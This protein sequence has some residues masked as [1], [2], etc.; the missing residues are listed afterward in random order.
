M[1]TKVKANVLANT[2]NVMDSVESAKENKDF[3]AANA[4]KS[5]TEILKDFITGETEKDSFK[6]SESIVKNELRKIQAEK[7]GKLFAPVC[8][9]SI[10]NY[11]GDAAEEVLNAEISA[12][13]NDTKN[14][15]V[16]LT[17]DAPEIFGDSAVVTYSLENKTYFGYQFAPESP[18]KAA[19]LVNYWIEYRK[20]IADSLAAKVANKK[21]TE[22]K[23]KKAENN[24]LEILAKKYGVSV[25]QLAVIL[26]ANAAK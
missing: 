15:T 7:Y 18:A 23:E 25:E 1:S 11:F 5:V 8:A 16:L 10:R 19:R 3:K 20:N 17:T 2:A 21:A 14:A 22:R 4:E 6:D 9:N 12:F 24:A 13:E 26:A